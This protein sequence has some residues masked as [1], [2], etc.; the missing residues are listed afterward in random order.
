M[1]T[2]RPASRHRVRRARTAARRLASPFFRAHPRL[3]RLFALGCTSR[4]TLIRVL[5]RVL[6]G[7]ASSN[8]HAAG[9]TS[10]SATSTRTHDREDD[11]QAAADKLG[12]HLFEVHL[13]LAVSAGPGNAARA[14]SQ[15]RR[16]AGAFGQFTV[17]RMAEIPSVTNPPTPAPS[18]PWPR[19]PA[20]LRGTRHA[21][22]PGHGHRPCPG[23]AVH[24]EPRT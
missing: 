8:G 10:F 1:L 9:P 6:G 19:I 22:A 13:R 16:M 5:A 11:L 3:A 14:K 17:P 7:V 2:V 24:R 21:L 23:H 20:L 12:R 18:A 4:W 15:L